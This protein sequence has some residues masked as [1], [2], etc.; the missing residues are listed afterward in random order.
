VWS[1]VRESFLWA[2]GER[3]EDLQAGDESDG[4]D[5]DEQE[6]NQSAVIFSAQ[7]NDMSARLGYSPDW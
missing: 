1:I 6:E 3:K 2:D 4:S 5:G 7:D